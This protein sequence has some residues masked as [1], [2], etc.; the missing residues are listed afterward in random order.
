M[1]N[2]ATQNRDRVLTNFYS[3]SGFARLT[4]YDKSTI[5]NFIARGELLP[6]YTEDGKSL[7]HV[8]SDILERFKR[9]R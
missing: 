7:I 1:E 6:Y 2:K 8:T 5:S 9:S 4:G 3:P